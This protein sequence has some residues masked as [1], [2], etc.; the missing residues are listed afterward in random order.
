MNPSITEAGARLM[1]R[2]QWSR[3]L[4]GSALCLASTCMVLS[5]SVALAKNAKVKAVGVAA[6][7]RGDRAAAR[8]KAVQDAQRKAVEQ[9]VGTLVSS[10]TVTENFQLLSD[11]IYSR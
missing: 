8:D 4:M 5:R 11:K 3:L 2:M 10:E 9:A 7:Y 1:N 6:I